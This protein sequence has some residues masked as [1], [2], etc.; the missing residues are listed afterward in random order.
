MSFFSIKQYFYKVTNVVLLSLIVPLALF[1]FIYVYLVINPP[2]VSLPSPELLYV[3][4]FALLFWLILILFISKK[5]KSVRKGQGLGIK[6]EQYLRLTTVRY[7]SQAF[8]S[9]ILALI[10][11]L[12]QDDG[13]TLIYLLHL[14][15]GALTWPTSRRV[16]NGLRLRGD[17]YQMVFYKKDIL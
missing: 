17:E 11:L 16:A 5:I 13:I 15:L 14:A 6:L 8:V 2:F 12:S 1:V 4:L 3:V 9:V 10:F 7:V